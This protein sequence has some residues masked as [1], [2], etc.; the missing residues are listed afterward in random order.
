MAE[1][2]GNVVRRFRKHHGWSQQQL[3]DRA[4]VVR[5]TVHR[6]E[7]SGNVGVLLL[8]QIA[9]ALDEDITVFFG[10]EASHAPA[11]S[12]QPAVWDRLKRE[13]RAQVLRFAYRLLGERVPPAELL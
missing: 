7:M 6:A 13:Q 12:R 9:N 3:A 11:A 4:G 5:E 10:A 1:A 2:Y 8:Q